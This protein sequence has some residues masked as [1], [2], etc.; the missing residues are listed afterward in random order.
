MVKI[1][2]FPSAEP[3]DP[4]FVEDSQF[5]LCVGVSGG[6]GVPVV[7][8]VPVFSAHSALSSHIQTE[9][10]LRRGSL[11]PSVKWIM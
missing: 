1:V 2:N 5:F 8:V 11:G 9:S 10:W 6:E 3:G 4:E 7:P